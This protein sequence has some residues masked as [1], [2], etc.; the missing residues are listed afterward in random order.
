M[1]PGGLEQNLFSL[2]RSKHEFDNNK[3]GKAKRVQLCRCTEVGI[4][5]AQLER[6]RT[7]YVPGLKLN[8][9]GLEQNMVKLE[10]NM[11]GLEQE[12]VHDEIEHA[13]VLCKYA[14]DGVQNAQLEQNVL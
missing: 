10:V 8:M 4:L 11:L 3:A 5:N 1:L 9:L 13:S 2:C 7:E 14:Q 12:Y 6:V